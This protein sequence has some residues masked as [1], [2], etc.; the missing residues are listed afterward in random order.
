MMVDLVEFGELPVQLVCMWVIGM[1]IEYGMGSGVTGFGTGLGVILVQLRCS[2]DKIK[3]EG[4]CNLPN[5]IETETEMLWLGWRC[6]EGFEM[7]N[8]MG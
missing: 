6:M 8:D 1:V 3:L 7:W 2:V 4:K 5:W